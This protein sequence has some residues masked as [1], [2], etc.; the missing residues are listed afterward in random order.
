MEGTTRPGVEPR[1]SIVKGKF[2]RRR[3]YSTPLVK[4]PDRVKNPREGSFPLFDAPFPNPLNQCLTVTGGSGPIRSCGPPNF[5]KVSLLSSLMRHA[6]KESGCIYRGNRII[7]D[8]EGP[9]FDDF[10]NVLTIDTICPRRIPDEM[11]PSPP[12]NAMI[13]PSA[14]ES[15]QRPRREAMTDV[16]QNA[17]E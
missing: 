8:A 6:R 1:V 12:D 16:P 5:Q 11:T 10:L 15:P 4:A 2:L 13:L 17:Q 9:D 3:K 14:I 7:D